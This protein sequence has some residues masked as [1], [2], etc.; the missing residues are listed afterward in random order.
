L[1]ED[2]NG[3]IL[4]TPQALDL[5]TR[6]TLKIAQQEV[7]DLRAR[8]IPAYSMAAPLGQGRVRVG[9][10][11]TAD[12]IAVVESLLTAAGLTASLVT[13]TGIVP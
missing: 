8:G 2:G 12:Q 3:T 1:V 10:F 5:G 4:R 6:E 9:A 11:E 13:R 7:S